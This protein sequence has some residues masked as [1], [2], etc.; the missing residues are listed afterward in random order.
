M[1]LEPRDYGLSCEKGCIVLTP[2]QV[3]LYID[4]C[5]QAKELMGGISNVQAGKSLRE[6]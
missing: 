1:G 4:F 2:Q 3:E 5:V 6:I